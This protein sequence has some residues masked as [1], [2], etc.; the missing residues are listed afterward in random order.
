MGALEPVLQR[1]LDTS[2]LE[3]GGSQI[4]EPSP[5]ASEGQGSEAGW[6]T[7]ADGVYGFQLLIP[8]DWTWKEL[9]ATGPGVPEDWPMTRIV[10]LFPQ[11]WEADLSRSGPPDPT[12]KPVVAPLQVEVVVGPAEQFRRVYPEP[13]QSETIEING[14]QVTV[15]REVF[16]PMWLARYVFQDPDNPEVWVVV[17][18]YLSGFPDRVEGNEALVKVLPA[19]V[20]TFEFVR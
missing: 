1:A 10:H 2:A 19:I 9:P 4:D 6:Q 12:A 16:D 11:A 18:D 14:L 5:V 20:A 8:Q 15:E 17:G 13:T 7:L 3:G